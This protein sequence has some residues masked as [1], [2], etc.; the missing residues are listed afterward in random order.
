LDFQQKFS[1]FI[2]YFVYNAIYKVFG[3][4]KALDGIKYYFGKMLDL[5]ATTFW[6]NFDPAWA[7]NAIRIDQLLTDGKSDAHAD[8]GFACFKGFRMSLCHGWS[9]G[10]VKLIK[11]I[12]D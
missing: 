3:K 12:A 8:Y 5:G 1:D 9:A 7:D 10:V 6:E 4:E 2:N 11:D